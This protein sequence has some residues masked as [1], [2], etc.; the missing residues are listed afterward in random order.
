MEKNRFK[1]LLESKMGDVK[2]LLVESEG[3]QNFVITNETTIE[4]LDE[5]LYE[6]IENSYGYGH[7]R[8]F[9]YYIEGLLKNSLVASGKS[10]EESK[11]MAEDFI[12]RYM[13]N[14]MRSI[15]DQYDYYE[16]TEEGDTKYMGEIIF[17]YTAGGDGYGFS[18]SIKDLDKLLD[19][20]KKLIQYGT[21]HEE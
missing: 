21:I 14:D 12:E 1:Q 8:S 3:S 19:D 2:P 10:E 5:Y 16:R 6:R 11:S 13:D 20:L 4:E 9:E 7:S 15:P 18:G 17:E